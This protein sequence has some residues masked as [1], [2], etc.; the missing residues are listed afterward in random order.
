MPRG[1]WELERRGRDERRRGGFCS[2]LVLD[3]CLSVTS[4]SDAGYNG[5]G[6]R[7][8][9]K[10]LSAPQ[11]KQAGCRCRD[12]S[13]SACGVSP[14]KNLRIWRWVW[15]S[16]AAICLKAESMQEPDGQK[17]GNDKTDSDSAPKAKETQWEK[18]QVFFRH[19]KCLVNGHKGISVCVG[20]LSTIAGAWVFN[21]V[22]KPIMILVVTGVIMAAVGIIG[23]EI[24]LHATKP[25]VPAGLA[26]PASPPEPAT[27]LP[28]STPSSNPD[29]KVGDALPCPLTFR[30]IFDTDF[31]DKYSIS[32][33]F[34][35]IAP[36]DD[37]RCQLG[38]RILVD[39]S[40]ISKYAAF[41]VPRFPHSHWLCGQIAENIEKFFVEIENSYL[42][43]MTSPGDTAAMNSK[44]LKF[45]GRVYLYHEDDLSL[46]Q[47]AELEELFQKH[48]RTAQFRGH[49][50]H[51]LHHNEARH[52]P[53]DLVATGMHATAVKPGSPLPDGSVK[54]CGPDGKS[55]AIADGTLI[56]LTVS[57][58]NKID[59]E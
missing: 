42:L 37:K 44:D 41:F 9:R 49:A 46:K 27:T 14:G 40:A 39:F 33:V 56:W 7:N 16:G 55:G 4:S 36:Q 8:P 28:T 19:L 3:H 45:S 35:V 5:L 29:Q 54:V 18:I 32:S 59:P 50:Y 58:P 1:I 22:D 21:N 47:L 12:G 6:A 34:T 20:I 38:F 13:A 10:R 15:I 11:P 51:I 43:Q 23:G 30:Q 17:S 31:S 48:E 52:L 2:N 53:R 57:R 25:P 24:Y 26:V